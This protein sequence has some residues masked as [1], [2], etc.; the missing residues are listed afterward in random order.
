MID[1]D[2][3]DDLLDE[4]EFSEYQIN[5]AS[6]FP[7]NSEEICG[8]KVAAIT[9]FHLVEL[10]KLENEIIQGK[11]IL[12]DPQNPHVEIMK[13][14]VSAAI[15][16]LG[17]LNLGNDLD[18]QDR[19]VEDAGFRNAIKKKLLRALPLRQETELAIEVIRY[20]NKSYDSKVKAKPKEDDE[21]EESGNVTSRR[22][23]SR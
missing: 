13:E 1:V 10:R 22:K 19:F 3:K 15:E 14:P 5:K 6:L 16:V 4:A 20:I 18:A 12:P 7:S 23:K 9:L 11:R 8:I 2:Q 21:G 17:F